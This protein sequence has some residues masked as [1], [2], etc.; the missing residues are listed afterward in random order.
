[1]IAD[2]V[3]R[4]NNCKSWVVSQFGISVLTLCTCVSVVEE[5][6]EIDFHHGDTE[7]TEVAQG[8]SNQGTTKSWAT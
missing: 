5:V 8:N 1:M 2:K 4:A 7:G 3:A 6:A